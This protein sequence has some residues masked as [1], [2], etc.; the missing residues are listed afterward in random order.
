M[1]EQTRG[2][3]QGYDAAF[4]VVVVLGLNQGVG[5]LVVR[6]VFDRDQRLAPAL[7]LPA[8]WWW[9]TCLTIIAATVAALTTITTARQ[10]RHPTKPSERATLATGKFGEDT[11]HADSAG[12]YD[13]ASAVVFLVG[14][15]NG[16][17]P[18]IARLVFDR[19]GLLLALPLRLPAPWW[20]ITSLAVIAATI[21]ALAAIDQA[22]E[23]HQHDDQ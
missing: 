17:A 19:D 5:P 11:P 9:I 22:K 1:D 2:G 16:V 8:P 12:A 15:Y 20:W 13:A 18:F 6:L 10:R 23:R 3:S 4:A 7:W 21:V 14:I